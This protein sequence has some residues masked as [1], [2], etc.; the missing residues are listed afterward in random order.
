MAEMQT[1]I[2]VMLFSILFEI[3]KAVN[4]CNRLQ[5]DL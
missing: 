4:L 1:G 2:S 5:Y 3:K